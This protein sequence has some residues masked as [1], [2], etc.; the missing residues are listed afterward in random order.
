MIQVTRTGVNY[1]LA[2]P[3]N[4]FGPH[5]YPEKLIPKSTL[6]MKRGLPAIVHGD[7]SYV[8][9]WLHVEDTVDALMTIIYNGELNTIYNI[10]GDF[11]CQNI[12]VLQKI[13]NILNIDHDKAWVHIEDRAGQ[14]V[15]YS[16]DDS[17]LRKLGWKP[18]RIF[19]EELVKITKT[20]DFSCFLNDKNIG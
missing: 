8:R 20:Q 5:Q 12:E 14:D 4:N 15:R 6:R 16:M 18:T 11:E 7:G 1:I 3:S 10:N 13:A 19:D 2:R 17:R 9:S